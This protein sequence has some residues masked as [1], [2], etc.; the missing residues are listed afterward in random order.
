[1]ISSEDA[2]ALDYQLY[3]HG[4]QLL[5]KSASEADFLAGYQTG[6]YQFS[7]APNLLDSLL[8]I[9]KINLQTLCGE[10]LASTETASQFG[11][12]PIESVSGLIKKLP[13]PEISA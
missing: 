3:Q 12:T 11:K 10:W 9:Y 5:K 4:A 2:K 13:P 6:K 7:Q 1:M 8:S